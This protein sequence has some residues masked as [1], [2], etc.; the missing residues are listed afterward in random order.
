ML[1]LFKL[2]AFSFFCPIYPHSF[3]H[4]CTNTRWQRKKERERKQSWDK[5]SL[6]KQLKRKLIEIERH[7]IDKK[8]KLNNVQRLESFPF[9]CVD[10]KA[11][12]EKRLGKKKRETE[13]KLFHNNLLWYHSTMTTLRR[14]LNLSHTL[15][16]PSGNLDF[17][18]CY[19]ASFLKVKSCGFTD[20]KFVANEKIFFPQRATSKLN[21]NGREG[22]LTRLD[23]NFCTT[24][25]IFHSLRCYSTVRPSTP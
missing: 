3:S 20:E 14:K 25:I 21:L 2:S 18:C 24:R 11:I 16:R 8:R 10:A 22:M 17:C 6:D 7:Y 23:F 4:S 1:L 15:S 9:V 5:N 12:F 19:F 13:S